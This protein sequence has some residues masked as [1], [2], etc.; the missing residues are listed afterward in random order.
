MRIRQLSVLV[1]LYEARNMTSAAKDVGM[2]QPALS[3][4]LSEL[5]TEL[6]VKLFAR[7]TR[8]FHP[9]RVCD[10]L[11]VHAK[12]V[13]GEMERSKKTVA[14][15]ANGAA[16]SLV[17]GTSPPAAPAL[18][19]KAIHL[20]RALHPDVHLEIYESTMETLLPQL[21][22]AR[23]DFCVIRIEQPMFEQNIRY[24]LLYQEEMR[25]VV[26]QEHMFAK[27]HQLDWADL[28]GSQWIGP[29]VA[30]PLRR[31]LEHEFALAGEP[32]PRYGIETSSTLMT[33]SLLQEGSL[34]A[35]MS[36]RVAEFFQAAGQ[37]SILPLTYLRSSGIGVL[38]LR[39]AQQ[40]AH[41]TA[42]FEALK[43]SARTIENAA[44]GGSAH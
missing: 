2:S 10:E 42:F 43:A 13:V 38:R 37:L 26:G 14:L 29:L 41:K 33:V 8:G 1:T 35:A 5:E 36:A 6:G 44:D 19:P 23:L 16:S 21:R 17:I 3:K 39:N 4:W 25:V 18:L 31:E 9:T 34:V 28:R 24:D 27:K 22:S 20:F 11:I 12:A 15:M 32:A 30:S 40:T 7:T